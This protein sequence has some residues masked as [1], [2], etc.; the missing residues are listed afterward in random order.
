MPLTDPQ[1]GER[2][3]ILGVCTTTRE[4]FV[5]EDAKEITLWA[6]D[7]GPVEITY[8]PISNDRAD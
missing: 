1:T 5:H 6:D 7:R 3:V 2:Q 4:I 8:R